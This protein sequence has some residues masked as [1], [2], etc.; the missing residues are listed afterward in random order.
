MLLLFSFYIFMNY[1]R[2]FILINYFWDSCPLRATKILIIDYLITDKL[3][4]I[5]YID[6]PE[7]LDSLLAKVFAFMYFT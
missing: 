4:I 5:Y 7:N 6:S 2:R 1:F 3:R